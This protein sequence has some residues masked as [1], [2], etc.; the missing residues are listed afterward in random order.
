MGEGVP[1]DRKKTA[2]EGKKGATSTNSEKK[3]DKGWLRDG[4]SSTTPT[5]DTLRNVTGDCYLQKQLAI[6]VDE[7]HL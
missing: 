3:K 2:G 7:R 4:H 5:Q 1:E 6:P